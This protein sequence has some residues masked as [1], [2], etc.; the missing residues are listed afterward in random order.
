[1]LVPVARGMDTRDG[2]ENIIRVRPV[3]VIVVVVV[4]VSVGK[5]R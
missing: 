2:V 4:V 1:M 5:I 3:V